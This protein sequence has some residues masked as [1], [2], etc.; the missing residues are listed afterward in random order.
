MAY[1]GTDTEY[2]QRLA[3]AVQ[4]CGMDAS[5]LDGLYRLCDALREDNPRFVPA[6]F[7]EWCLDEI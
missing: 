4:A 7:M 2:R 3:T 5:W 1:E 6:I